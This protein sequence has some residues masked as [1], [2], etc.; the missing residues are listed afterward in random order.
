MNDIIILIEMVN[1]LLLGITDLFSF[2]Q[3]TNIVYE[4]PASVS[5]NAVVVGSGRQPTLPG[6]LVQPDFI[7]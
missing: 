2:R 6:H 7:F 5:V 3:I 1:G 4:K